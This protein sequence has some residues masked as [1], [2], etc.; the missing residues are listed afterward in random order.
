MP[1]QSKASVALWAPVD[2]KKLNAQEEQL[3]KLKKLNRFC[4]AVAGLEDQ[5]LQGQ[6]L[7]NT[8]LCRSAGDVDD[9][10]D[11]YC[12]VRRVGKASY[13]QARNIPHGG[14][15]CMDDGLADKFPGASSLV[16]SGY[17]R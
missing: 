2:K 6:L 12:A 8:I 14:F 9:R 1:F 10:W 13:V 5:N 16:A 3:F 4:T 17:V 15:G 7:S 11:R